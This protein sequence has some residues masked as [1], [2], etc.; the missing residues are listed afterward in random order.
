[1]KSSNNN[2]HLAEWQQGEDCKLDYI[3]RLEEMD[4]W[5]KNNKKEILDKRIKY[6]DDDKEPVGFIDI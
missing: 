1:M 5:L 4:K 3:L 6:N 2:K